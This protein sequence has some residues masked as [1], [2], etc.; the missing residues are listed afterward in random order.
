MKQKTKIILFLLF[1]AIVIIFF[2]NKIYATTIRDLE[3]KFPVLETYDVNVIAHSGAGKSFGEN[4]G[5]KDKVQIVNSLGKI[6]QEYIVIVPGDVTG[7][8]EVKLYD[9]FKILN[10]S[11][12]KSPIDE[13]DIE[14]RDY[15][16][17]G[18]VNTYDALQYMKETIKKKK[19]RK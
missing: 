11:V 2:P 10:N 4:V 13:L 16:E 14:I 3:A 8:G 7:N 17:D 1:F 12:K 18:K 6:L 9:A 19:G 5:S 15:N